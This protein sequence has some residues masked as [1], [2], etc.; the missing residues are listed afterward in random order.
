MAWV[1]MI[2]TFMPEVN[3]LNLRRDNDYPNGVPCGSLRFLKEMQEVSCIR[4]SPLP[5]ALLSI[6]C[7]LNISLGA[8]YPGL[9]LSQSNLYA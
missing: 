1:G 5:S 3:R 6:R 4:S 9:S 8:K 7:S 2:V